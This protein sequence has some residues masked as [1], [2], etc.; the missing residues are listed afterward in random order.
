MPRKLGDGSGRQF[1]IF[2]LNISL[3]RFAAF[4]QRIAAQ[5]DDQCAFVFH[6]VSFKY[7]R[8][9]V[10]S[11]CSVRPRARDP[12]HRREWEGR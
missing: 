2:T 5:R 12:V 1:D 9:P 6:N 10:D 11:S 4:E 8:V 7:H 3:Q